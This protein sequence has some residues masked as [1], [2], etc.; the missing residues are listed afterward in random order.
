VPENYQ[1]VIQHAMAKDPDQR[2][3][4]VRWHGNRSIPGKNV[5]QP[6][7]TGWGNLVSTGL[8]LKPWRLKST[9]AAQHV[10]PPEARIPLVWVLGG[11]AGFGLIA[12]WQSCLG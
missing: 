4:L 8:P 1:V 10:A 9:C 5:S 3:R 11:L 2:L 6:D 12:A 7:A